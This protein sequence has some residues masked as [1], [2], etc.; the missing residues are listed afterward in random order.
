ME[1]T[2]ALRSWQKH[3]SLVELGGHQ[4]FVNEYGDRAAPAL[5]FLHGFPTASFDYVRLVPF[6]SQS[7]RL[8]FFDFVGFGYSAKPRPY[9]YSLIEQA[10]LAEALCRHLGITEVSLCAHD[11]GSSV[12]LILLA[13]KLLPVRRLILLNGSVL[14][15][16]YRPLL[17]QRLLLHP[18]TGPLI[19]QLG[20]IRRSLF[21]RQ[22]RSLFPQPPPDDEI[23]AFYSL[24]CHNDGLAIYHLLIQYLAER[25]LHELTW[26]D[27]LTQHTAPLL[28]LWGQRDPVSRPQIAESVV[29]RRPDACYIPL[30][31]VGHYPQ[32]EAA[33][34]V[35]RHILDFLRKHS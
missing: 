7:Y 26:L 12:A 35:A 3:G 31:E 13:R 16:H 21:A 29:E 22:F 32:W 14:L 17:S 18:T 33:G 4:L 19:S 28:I 25:R 6:L 24:I 23:D 15:K 11:M 10:Q 5:L 1:T 34:T 20:L 9:R 8:L 27:A 2:E 30:T